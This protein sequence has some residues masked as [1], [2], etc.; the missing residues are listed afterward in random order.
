MP[1]DKRRMYLW[2]FLLFG[3]GAIITT[4]LLLI[5]KGVGKNPLPQANVVNVPTGA[6]V[7]LKADYK[8]PLDKSSQYVNPF[9]KIKNPFDSL[10]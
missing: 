1:Q 5:K 10:Q 7:E 6:Q 9:S 4:G 3:F 8:N 2:A